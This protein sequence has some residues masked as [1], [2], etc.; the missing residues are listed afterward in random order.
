MIGWG[1]GDAAHLDA[2][3][4]DIAYRIRRASVDTHLKTVTLI[5]AAMVDN[6]GQ[7]VPASVERQPIF[8]SWSD[9]DANTQGAL[10]K[11]TDLI[12]TQMKIYDRRMNGNH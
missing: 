8:R 2:C 3:E 1:Y 9:L 5:M 4:K 11:A 12:T 6:R 10:Q 7:I